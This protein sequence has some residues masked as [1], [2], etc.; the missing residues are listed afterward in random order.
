MP[1]TTEQSIDQLRQTLTDKIFRA[2]ALQKNRPLTLHATIKLPSAAEDPSRPIAGFLYLVNLYRPFDD[3]FIGL[4]N[5]SRTD[6]S[7]LWLAHLQ[8]QLT[9]AL[10]NVLDCTETQAADL[11]TSQHW[12]RTMVWQLS[13]TNGFLS[14][15]SPDSSTTFTYP[16]EIAK[17][18]VAVTSQLSQRSM[19][20]H[21]IGLVRGILFKHIENRM[22]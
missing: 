22:H 6:C 19:E 17:D 7:T 18:L 2:Y 15:T 4:W 9:Q 8:K 20:V 12:L 1:V 5:N 10:P 11:R 13:I 16:I 14:S 3:T 21:G